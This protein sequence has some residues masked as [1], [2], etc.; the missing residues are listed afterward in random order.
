M[1]RCDYCGRPFRQMAD[2]FC[3]KKDQ[4]A[5]PD[6]AM[7]IVD[8]VEYDLRDRRGIRHEWD[9]VDEDVQ[10]E[11]RDTLVEKVRAELPK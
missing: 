1:S 3:D 9:Q 7:R 2:R 4:H 11:I 5:T 6:L 10:D 8:A